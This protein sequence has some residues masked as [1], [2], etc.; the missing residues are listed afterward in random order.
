LSRFSS[1]FFGAALGCGSGLALAA[2]N[3][4]ALCAGVTLG[5]GGALLEF[6]FVAVCVV[7]TTTFAPLFINFITPAVSTTATRTS[8]AVSAGLK[9]GAVNVPA[10]QSRGD[11]VPQ[12]RRHLHVAFVA[13]EQL[14][15]S[16]QLAVGC[17]AFGAR[18]EVRGDRAAVAFVQFAVKIIFEDGRYFLALHSFT[19]R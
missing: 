17:R 5:A 4:G 10:N 9:R 18:T 13:H 15:L 6:V 16:L 8:A 11:G 12:L 3:C 2:V 14:L 1:R 7:A 19:P